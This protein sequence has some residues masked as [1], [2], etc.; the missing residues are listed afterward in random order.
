MPLDR[1]SFPRIPGVRLPARMMQPYR[2]DYGPD[3]RTR[4]IVTLQPPRVGGAFRPLVLQVDRD[5]NELAGIRLPVIR[6]PLATYTGWNLRHPD[7][8]SPAELYSMVGSFIPFPG[9]RR[10]RLQAGDPRL[11]IAE[12]H[13]GREAYLGEFEPRRN[14]WRDSAIS[15]A[16]MSR[17][18]PGR[19]PSCGII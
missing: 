6:V 15:S 9:T 16:A 10:E 19:R 11:S 1:M 14:A 12:R 13:A 18:S 17:R 2:L 5:G 4:G 7:I 3:F 8:G